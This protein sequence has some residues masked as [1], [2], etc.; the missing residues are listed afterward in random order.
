MSL[1]NLQVALDH[2][3]VADAIAATVAVGNEVD[4]IEAGTVLM[5]EVGSEVVRVIRELFPDK[6]VVA[7]TK[8]ADAGGTVAKNCA[9][10]GA[11]WMTCICS[12]TVATMKAAAKEI[13]EI[14]VELYGN[15]TYE[16]AQTWLDAGMTQA[17]YHQSRDALLAG[18]TWGEK[19]LQKVRKLI[20]MGFK[21][22]VTGGLTTETLALFKG[23]DVYTFIAGRGIT[24]APDP[25]AAAR[26][27]KQRITD[28]WG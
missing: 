23:I 10:R 2:S 21:V 19:D 9:N 4:I 25:A 5:L 14:Q 24:E 12:A 6:I 16:E 15:W 20:E 8:C 1:P 22:S 13:D 17:I 28:I 27:F 3:N 7:D 11:N 26:A 18:E